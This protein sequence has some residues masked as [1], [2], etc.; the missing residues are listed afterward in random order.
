[1]NFIEIMGRMKDNRSRRP[2]RV[3]EDGRL[4]V[5]AITANK[6]ASVVKTKALAA[7]AGYTAQDVLSESATEG[8]GT[9]YEFAL[10][11]KP[12]GSILIIGARVGSES[13]DITPRIDLEIY[14]KYPSCNL[15]DN[16]PY[17]GPAPAD[18]NFYWGPIAMMSLSDK[19]D[20]TGDSSAIVST[21]T[22][23]NL[24]IGI[25]CENNNDRIFIVP[26]TLD[27]FTQTATDDLTIRI[28][29]LQL[30]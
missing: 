27:A 29:A 21:S 14:T 20:A 15:A 12:G 2:V 28:T 17:V 19:A 16:V 6:I 3:D 9:P 26:V 22:V 25:V 30:D 10:A 8:I 23:G 24:P 1:M 13:E 18:K 11:S 7:A 4:E 5:I